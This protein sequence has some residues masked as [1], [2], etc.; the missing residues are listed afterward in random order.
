MKVETLA[1]Y[2]K[3]YKQVT[4]FDNAFPLSCGLKRSVSMPG[5]E[6]V[7]DHWSQK[8]LEFPEN[9][10]TSVRQCADKTTGEKRF[11]KLT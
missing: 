6:N 2:C 3:I 11:E 5:V 9:I 4:V 7:S 1:I 8:I 10:S